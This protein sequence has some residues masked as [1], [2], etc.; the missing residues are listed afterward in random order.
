RATAPARKVNTQ[1]A[2]KQRATAPARK[3]STPA[4]R[5]ASMTTANNTRSSYRKPT[6][7]VYA[8]PRYSAPANT[9][10]YH[11]RH[12]YGGHYYHYAYP[13]RK[14]KFHYHHDTYIHHYNV[15]YYPSY[16]N[17]YWTRSMYRNYHR[18]YPEFRWNYNY[19]HRIQT[20]SVFDAQYNLGEVAMVYGRVYATWHN[21]ETDDYLLFF[22]GDFPYQ[23]FTVVLP[24]YVARKFSWR[25]E[26]YFLGEHITTTGLITT[27]DGSP[28]IVV[29]NKRQVGIY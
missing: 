13:T 26:R 3:V 17:I 23:Q 5:P 10:K 1:Q 20:I 8:E 15:L 2:S 12:Y 25:P 29:K 7:K 19:G 14:V 11:N 16:T 6:N 28:E 4:R 21:K 18:W 24:G 27:F 22:G 9:R